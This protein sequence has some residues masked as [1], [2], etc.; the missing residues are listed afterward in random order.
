MI[1]SPFAT[2][3]RAHRLQLELHALVRLLVRH[4][5]SLPT[6]RTAYSYACMYAAC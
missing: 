6:H 5:A 3:D 2:S 4:I 1:A